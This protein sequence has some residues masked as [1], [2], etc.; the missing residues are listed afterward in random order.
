MEGKRGKWLTLF[1]L[2]TAGTLGFLFWTDFPEMSGKEAFA[3]MGYSILLFLMM[4]YEFFIDKIPISLALILVIPIFL[5][6]G[7]FVA[8]T[9]YGAVGLL[10]LLALGN[11]FIRSLYFANM[12][13]WSTLTAAGFYSL[14]GGRLHPWPVGPW[15]IIWFLSFSGVLFLTQIFLLR[16][17]YR[18]IRQSSMDLRKPIRWILLAYLI[19]V[20]FGWLNYLIF[21]ELN[22]QGLLVLAIPVMGVALLFRLYYEKSITVERLKRLYNL[23]VALNSKL[24]L[25]QSLSAVQQGFRYLF[26]YDLF[27]IFLRENEKEF[28]PAITDGEGREKVTGLIRS[29]FFL[30]ESG[31]L[32]ELTHRKEPFFIDCERREGLLGSLKGCGTLA[33]TPLRYDARLIGFLLIGSWREKAYSRADLTLFQI[34]ANQAAI[35][36]ANAQ[37]FF[38]TERRSVTDELTGLYNFR[39]FSQ[40]IEEQ[41]EEAK[42]NHR[43]LSLLIIDIDHFKQINDTFGHLSG[44]RALIG[45]AEQLKAS[46]R[47][48]DIVARYGGEEFTILLPGTSSKEAVEIAERIRMQVEKMR[49]RIEKDLGDGADV[50][51][52]ITVSIGISSY[53]EHAEDALSLMRNADRA[54]YVG[55][56]HQGRNRVAVYGA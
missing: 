44:N 39:F 24:D 6:Y 7:P 4:K 32:P 38:Y 22:L 50:Y 36:I 33:V 40:A 30:E 19:A 28:R 41:V 15:D 53:P 5:H 14:I 25:Q 13:V 23:S 37:T 31:I 3:L 43:P 49:L 35:A 54:M 20:P 56:K 51:L 10:I 26:H 12:Y 9:I 18:F 46:V 34:L 42:R 48:E 45:L 47:K 21:R 8:A 16:F 1:T 52:R 17:Y 29:P 27:S 2:L 55:A 11:P